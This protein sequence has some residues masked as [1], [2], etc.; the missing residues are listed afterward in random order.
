MSIP[1]IPTIFEK[2]L[3]INNILKLNMDV[4]NVVKGYLFHELDTVYKNKKNK[5][6]KQI[7][8]AW[9]RVKD[10]LQDNEEH[11]HFWAKDAN[12]VFTPFLISNA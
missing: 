2:Q 3:L 9:S 1:T 6:I 10:N 8:M 12:E 5:M 7:N 11:W 4:L